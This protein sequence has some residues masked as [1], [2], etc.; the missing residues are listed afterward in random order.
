MVLDFRGSAL[1]PLRNGLSAI[2]FPL[3]YLVDRPVRMMDWLGN[4]M[5]SQEVL[6][7]E[8]A[9]LKAQ[10]FFLKGQLQKLT[11]LEGENKDLRELLRSTPRIDGKV[12]AAQLLAIMPSPYVSELTLNKGS[13]DGIYTGQPVLDPHGILGQVI[14]VG[15]KTSQVMLLSDKR[16]AVPVQ[17]V[18]NGVRGIAVGQ[19]ELGSLSLVHLPKSVD[20]RVGDELI[21]SGLGQRYPYGYPVGKVITIKD[22]PGETFV[23]VTLQPSSQIDRSRLVL[24]VWPDRSELEP[25]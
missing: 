7:Q 19:G 1:Q 15:L 11:S 18:R 23:T 24:L 10:L 13:Q 2:V 20:I 4:K 22:D 17:I 5:A 14:R 25:T 8:N 3:H 6:A 12:L 9:S 21:S 16:S